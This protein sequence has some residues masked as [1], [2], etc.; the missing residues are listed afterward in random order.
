MAGSGESLASVPVPT[1]VMAYALPL[2]RW[3]RHPNS[4]HP[5]HLHRCLESERRVPPPLLL[6]T[7]LWDAPSSTMAAE[8]LNFG[9]EW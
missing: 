7:N 6:P 5:L 4:W 3:V 2:G 8:T 1:Q 9:P